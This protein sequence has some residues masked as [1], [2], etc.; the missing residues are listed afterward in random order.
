MEPNDDKV[1]IELYYESLCPYCQEFIEGS[2]FNNKDIWQVLTFEH[3]P[4]EMP[5]RRKW[6]QLV[7]YLPAWSNECVGNMI[8]ACVIN[9]YD[10]YTQTLPFMIWIEVSPS[11]WTTKY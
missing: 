7:F 2:A 5:H 11:N 3:G 10:W 1:H 6:I 4:T 9:M 8:E